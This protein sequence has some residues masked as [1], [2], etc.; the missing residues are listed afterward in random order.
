M[1]DRLLSLGIKP[2]K[3]E[4]EDWSGIKLRSSGVIVAHGGRFCELRIFWLPRHSTV[5]RVW[6]DQ[7]LRRLPHDQCRIYYRQPFA[8]PNYLAFDYFVSG[9]KTSMQTV[10]VALRSLDRVAEVK[11]SD[12][13]VAH[14][15]N[16]RISSRLLQRYGWERH[17]GG[18]TSP[19]IIRR[20]YGKY[21][22]SK[23]RIREFTP[24][25]LA[26]VALTRKQ[27]AS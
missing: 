1:M 17:L 14:L 15:K 22:A 7:W 16:S 3:S 6:M 10:D 4:S 5:W 27:S 26:K 12:A 11:R 20:F 2:I 19:H 13:I 24:D 18:E 25:T 21:P 9:S 23:C 8:A